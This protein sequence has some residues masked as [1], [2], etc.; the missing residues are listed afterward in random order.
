MGKPVHFEI[1]AENVQR[2]IRFYQEVFG[3]K[4]QTWEGP[5]EYWL[6]DGGPGEGINGAI[7]TRPAPDFTT[8]NTIGVSSL[9]EA[10]AKVVAAGGQLEGQVQTIPGVGRFSYGRDS[11]GNRIGILE[12]TAMGSSDR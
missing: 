1:G 4:V 8:V 5:M 6:V 10:L 3:W 9:E 11:E 2:A 12:P 7:M